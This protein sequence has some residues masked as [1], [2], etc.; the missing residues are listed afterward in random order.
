MEV[1][2]ETEMD[3]CALHT[4]SLKTNRQGQRQQVRVAPGPMTGEYGFLLFWST[5]YLL[6]CRLKAAKETEG[7]GQ[8]RTHSLGGRKQLSSQAR[9][10]CWRSEEVQEVVGT[11]LSSY[12]GK[13]GSRQPQAEADRRWT[14][15]IWM[16]ASHR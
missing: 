11:S 9:S 3:C 14:G 10:C 1:G 7:S 2:A 6:I 12:G 8:G 5:G 16:A 4:E 15:R 13:T